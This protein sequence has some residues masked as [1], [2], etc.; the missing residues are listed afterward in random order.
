[1]PHPT[2]RALFS[3]FALTPG[4]LAIRSP[5]VAAAPLPAG[6]PTD[7]WARAL[8]GHF[9][10]APDVAYM[11]TG[12]LGS[13]PRVV[14]GALT[15][16]LAHLEEA[17]PAHVYRG[18]APWHPLSGYYPEDAIRGKLGA[19]LGADG[20][21]FALTRNAT[22]GMNFVGHGLDLAA[23]DEVLITDQEHPG[24]RSVWDLRAK[25]HGIRVTEVPLHPETDTP[26]A[27]VDRFAAAMGPKTR[28]LA[29]PH[30]TSG[31]GMV[32]PVDALC[33]LARAK[34][35]F[36]VIDGAQAPGQVPV[37]LHGIGCDAYFSSPHKWLCAPKGSGFL[38]VR[39]AAQSQLWTTLAGGQWDAQDKGMFRFMQFGTGCR[40]HLVGY[41]ATLDFW[42]RL[43][44]D[45]VTTHDRALADRL[46]AGLGAMDR[47]RIHSPIHPGLAGAMVN[48]S[49]EGV[50][51]A[52]LETAL[53]DQ[54]RIRV[55]KVGGERV[56]QCCH[57]YNDRSAVDT[58]LEIAAALAMG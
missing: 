53:W 3:A 38:Y 43:G 41:E 48:W 15:A 31:R 12:T 33:A 57:L 40:S 22:M 49:L 35:L 9:F 29:V 37:D 56:R 27:V 24:G 26:Q 20:A 32:L 5:A 16:H 50:P 54:A 58:T 21:E 6:P 36:S 46:R 10:I 45:T 11:N 28:V 13:V 2:R 23:G 47:A 25:R 30:I 18:D 1:M 17:L 8:R 51:G 55:R 14:M 52:T 42:T 7:D 19:L 39:T 34:G 4:L 44:I